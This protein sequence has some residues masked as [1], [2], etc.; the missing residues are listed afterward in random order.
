[1]TASW[2]IFLG[3][4]STGTQCNTDIWQAREVLL[5]MATRGFP[6]GIRFTKSSSG[7]TEFIYIIAEKTEGRTSRDNGYTGY[8]TIGRA[9][10]VDK[11]LEELQSGNPRQ[12]E[13]IH[14]YSVTRGSRAEQA[15]QAAHAVAKRS[16]RSDEKGGKEWYYSRSQFDFIQVIKLSLFRFLVR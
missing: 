7:N 13:C 6:Y 9:Y 11:K 2:L 16:Y 10:N 8:Y 15:E 14:S 3:T 12:L 4:I 5:E 1:M